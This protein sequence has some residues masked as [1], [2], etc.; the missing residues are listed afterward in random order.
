VVLGGGRGAEG[1][2][3]VQDIVDA[4]EGRALVIPVETD[5]D[6]L[7][8]GVEGSKRGLRFQAGAAVRSDD[9]RAGSKVDLRL[10]PRDKPGEPGPVGDSMG[11]LGAHRRI[12]SAGRPVVPR[13]RVLTSPAI[14][15]RL[16]EIPRQQELRRS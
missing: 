12:L 11:L 13:G 15:T 16:V 6:S 7:G 2:L 1:R 9:E 8:E 4:R 10:R 5:A 14:R 3:D